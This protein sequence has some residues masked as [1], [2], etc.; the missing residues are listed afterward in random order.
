M[1]M[2]Q[3]SVNSYNLPGGQIILYTGL[4]DHLDTDEEIAVVIAHEVRWTPVARHHTDLA[5]VA[6]SVPILHKLMPFSRRKELEADLIGVML[7]AAAGFDPRVAAHTYKKLGNITGGDP[8][9]SDYYGLYPSLTKRIEALSQ[10]KVLDEA[11]RLY[12]A[13]QQG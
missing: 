8:V 2:R 9:W 5:N 3:D 11:M 10:A 1:V 13:H 6:R 4:L 12:H 7:M